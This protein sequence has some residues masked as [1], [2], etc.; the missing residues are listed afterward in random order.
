MGKGFFYGGE[1][2]A[3]WKI[4]PIGQ[5]TFLNFEV[6]PTEYSRE[7]RVEVTYG[8]LNNGETCRVVA[9]IEFQKEA[10]QVI[11]ANVSQVQ[12]DFLAGYLNQ[13]VEICDH[14]GEVSQVY[15]D[16]IERQYLASGIQEQRYAV[17]ISVR[18]V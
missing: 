9:P 1:G 11:W 7:K 8:A 12:Y 16:G 18:E 6:N 17:N 5:E 10:Y 13:R 15:L 3:Q 14:L 4:R 2:M